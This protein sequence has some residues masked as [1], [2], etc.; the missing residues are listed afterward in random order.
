[1]NKKEEEEGL[2]LLVAT[3]LVSILAAWVSAGC[4]VRADCACALPT[5]STRRGLRPAPTL[6]PALLPSQLEQLE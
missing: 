5:T 2:S 3:Y 1:M 4:G 6:K